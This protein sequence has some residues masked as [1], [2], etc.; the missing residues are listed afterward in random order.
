VKVD[1]GS[2][3]LLGDQCIADYAGGLACDCGAP[4]FV[5]LARQ[6]DEQ[7]HNDG[8]GVPAVPGGREPAAQQGH[9]RTVSF[10]H[11]FLPIEHVCTLRTGTLCACITSGVSQLLCMVAHRFS[12]LKAN[13][14]N[15]VD[16]GLMDDVQHAWWTTFLNDQ[17]S[18]D[19]AGK[20]GVPN[21]SF[22]QEKNPNSFRQP[23][24][25]LRIS[26]K[27]SSQSHMDRSSRDTVNH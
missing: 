5:L 15:L 21:V 4:S 3:N 27:T 2:R 24:K 16:G 14:K 7:R 26:V 23:C 6:A 25:C 11:A 20:A 19:W 8:R 13:I 18:T 22:Q 1:I 12:G 17:E 10:G 9:R